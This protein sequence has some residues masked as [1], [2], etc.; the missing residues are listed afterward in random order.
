MSSLKI[1]ET[2][3]SI[4]LYEGKTEIAMFSYKVEGY[5]LYANFVPYPLYSTHISFFDFFLQG[6]KKTHETA[7]KL[8][9][10][11]I[12]FNNGFRNAIKVNP[13]FQEILDY[14]DSKYQVIGKNYLTVS[15]SAHFYLHVTKEDYVYFAE[16]S[17]VYNFISL[18]DCV[19]QTVEEK[20]I[21]EPTVSIACSSSNIV[22]IEY[23]LYYE[24]KKDCIEFSMK[25]QGDIICTYQKKDYQF[26]TTTYDAHTWKQTWQEIFEEQYKKARVKA[27]FDLPMTYLNNNIRKLT[28]EI[29]IEKAITSYFH[30]I[31]PSNK[32]IENVFA[33]AE[34]EQKI[35]SIS[36]KIFEKEWVVLANVDTHFFLYTTNPTC[37]D[38]FTVYT[39]PSIDD[40]LEAYYAYIV[41]RSAIVW[42]ERERK[43]LHDFLSSKLN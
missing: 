26:N 8:G 16:D 39:N 32:E 30:T 27:L 43:Q 1:V 19:V 35:H 4:H 22:S 11:T 2:E 33:R 29:P 21:Q 40:V 34:K 31:Y 28:K 38:E 42:K 18:I 9:V 23:E 41:K 12:I 36:E 17:Q 15:Y 3:E 13:V 7:E 6:E 5:C 37:A 10:K 25:E 14:V 24:G 20:S